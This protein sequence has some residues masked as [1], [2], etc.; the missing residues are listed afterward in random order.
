MNFDN[1]NEENNF[2]ISQRNLNLNKLELKN[3]N[4]FIQN[5]KRKKI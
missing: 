3:I 5:K 2:I 4:E 1:N